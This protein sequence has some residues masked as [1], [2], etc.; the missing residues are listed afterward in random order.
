M[1]FQVMTTV[2]IILMKIRKF[3]IPTTIVLLPSSSVKIVELVFLT[4]GGV[5]MIVTVLTV[6]MK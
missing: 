6:P 4:D 2:V 5:T 3:V 1:M